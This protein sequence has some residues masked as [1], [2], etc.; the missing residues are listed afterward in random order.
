MKRMM[1]MTRD[2]VIEYAKD[3]AGLIAAISKWD[4][5]GYPF[6]DTDTGAMDERQMVMAAALDLA[7]NRTKEALVAY[8]NEREAEIAAHERMLETIEATLQEGLKD[9]I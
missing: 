6:Y 7:F 4:N 1:I 8:A 2:Q 9:G 5:V 3:W